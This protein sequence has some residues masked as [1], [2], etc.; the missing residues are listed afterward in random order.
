M[1]LHRAVLASLAAGLAAVTVSQAQSVAPNESGLWQIWVA[2]TNAGDDHASVVTACSD[3][4]AS[5]PQ[6]PLVVVV[7]GLEAWRLLKMGNTREA[8]P[9]LESMVSVPE[10]ATFLQTTGAEMARGWLSR[11]DRE[12]VLISLKKVYV[13]DIEF[14]A[15]LDLIKS[16]KKATMPPFSDRWGTPWSYR[17]G[18]TIKGMDTQHY[19]LESTRLGAQSDLATALAL[20]YADRITPEPVRRLPASADTVEFMTSTGKSAFMPPGGNAEGATFAYMGSNLIVMAD[21]NHWR[22]MPKPR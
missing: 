6:D 4:R 11:I 22:I 5:S 2:S 9:L 8:V 21:G 13:R 10:K 20:P 12:K 17:L 1:Q 19:V 3:F 7:A 18:S 15:S 14:P 16:L